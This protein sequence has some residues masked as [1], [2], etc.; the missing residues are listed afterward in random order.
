M[1]QLLSTIR[2]GLF[3]NG[4]TSTLGTVVNPASH[5]TGEPITA[6]IAHPIFGGVLPVF[7]PPTSN[8]RQVIPT[9]LHL[10]TAHLPEAQ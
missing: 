2:H 9:G 8:P 10:K 6:P 5:L 4:K 3:G 1:I 7:H